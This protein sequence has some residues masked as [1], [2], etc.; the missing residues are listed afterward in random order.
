MREFLDSTTAKR[1]TSEED[2]WR[3]GTMAGGITNVASG[4]QTTDAL[5]GLFR[6]SGHSLTYNF[7]DT[8]AYYNATYFTA[9]S[10]PSSP[11]FDFATFA[12]A[13]A[14][15]EAAI[16]KVIASELMAVAPLVYTKTAPGAVADSSF[17]MA[18]LLPDAELGAPPG[19][20]GYYPGIVQRG[21]DAWFNVDQPRFNNVQVGD[22]AYYVVLHE[23]GHTVGLKHG[24][25]NDRPGPT[26]DLL[27]D[28]VDS[29]EFSVMTYHRYIGAPDVPVAGDTPNG[30]FPQSLMMYDIAAIQYM[31]GANFNHNSGN[32]VYTFSPTTGEMFVNGVGQGTPED[33]HIFRTIW[34]G[35]G[36][37]TYD[38]SNYT[39]DLEID[40][41]PG[42]WSDFHSGQL[43]H[44]SIANDIYAR[45]NVFN[46][47]QFEGDTRSLIENATGGSGDDT[48][49]G[50][51]ANNVLTG[52]GGNDWLIGL[53][54]N[55][56]LVGGGGADVLEGGVGGDELSG[57]AGFDFASYEHAAT[58]VYASL[59]S[60]A[61]NSGEAFHDMYIGIEGLIGS[62]HNDT[63]IGNGSAN[64]L[65]GGRG[66][67]TLSGL[68]GAD[69][70][71]GGAG[72]DS[73]RGG[74]GN[75]T[76]LFMGGIGHDT[77]V[78]WQDGPWFLAHDYI[79]FQGMGLSMA[80]LSIS[81][82]GGNAV[83]SVAALHGDITVLGV[84]PGSLGADDFLF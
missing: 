45:G 64:T 27:P 63:L 3:T 9:G 70:L 59:M 62:A 47:L 39:S 2:N 52:N 6:W 4:V 21:G 54:G 66:N 79:S 14:S 71:D 44:L 5:L 17:A 68:G 76:F 24:H 13:T 37:D 57:G 30:S 49:R 81:Y 74:A 67:D 12:A 48:I 53:D 73:L 61:L 22:S 83:V 28:D 34:D 50:N 19:G 77:I 10:V 26:M 1:L 18:S 23:L 82:C 42:G 51:S 43:A 35:N 36:T 55:D 7:P 41:A 65:R 80:D 29:F 32:T 25:A 16:D 11:A 20:I 69:I 72:N 46:A 75:D 40:L 56:R 84:L 8:A 60:P 38:F 31:Y 33:N 58:G 15:L 78:D